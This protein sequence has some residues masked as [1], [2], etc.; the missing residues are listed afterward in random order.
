[1]IP[2]GCEPDCP[3]CRYRGLS[4]AESNRRKQEWAAHCLQGV[5]VPEPIREP[6]L[7]WG[8]R[9]KV[10]LHAEFRSRWEFGLL[11]RKGRETELVPIPFC[12]LQAPEL[13]QRLAVLAKLLPP[14]IPLAFV[15]ASGPL[16]TLVLKCHAEE[17]WRD[18]ARQAE[19]GLAE[20]GV[21]GLFLNWNPAAG[22]RA[23][24]SRHQEKIFGLEVVREDG[25]A[26]G[27]LAF[28]QQITELETA[29]HLLAEKHLQAAGC[30]LVVDLYCGAGTTLARWRGLRWEAFGVELGGEACTLA[31]AN[32]PGA[33]LL[34]GRVEDRLGQL[35]AALGGRE[36]VVYTNPPRSGQ[37]AATVEWL[38]RLRPLRLAYLSCNMRSLSAELKALAGEY[39]VETV[40]PYDFFPQTDH[41]EA[42]ALLRR[43]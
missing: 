6:S 13:N 8:Y 32:A 42:L 21:V 26:Y 35:E 15:Q 12:P 29:A 17:R 28:R 1:M 24:S 19:A 23:I 2:A 31:A 40:Q 11:R 25:L 27:A 37:G 14:E 34:R 43:R 41:V 39:E 16:F 33:T 18:W 5:C 30:S 22:R 38:R 20:A 36:F 10:L 3:G 4:L 7:R 9:R